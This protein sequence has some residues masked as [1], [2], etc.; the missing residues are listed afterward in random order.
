MLCIIFL[1][2]AFPGILQVIISNGLVFCVRDWECKSPDSPYQVLE[3]AVGAVVA[4]T[5]FSLVRISSRHLV[6]VGTS[7]IRS[8][9]VGGGGGESSQ[10]RNIVRKSTRNIP[11]IGKEKSIHHH[12]GDTP[13]SL[14]LGLRL[15]GVYPSF[16]TYGVH[17]FPL[18]SQENG[19]HHSFFCS[20][21]SGSGDRPRKEGSRSGGVYSFFPC[22]KIL[23]PLLLSQIAHWHFPK[24]FSRPTR[25]GY[26]QTRFSMPNMTGRPG[27][28][29]MEMNGGSSAPY[30]AR[31]PCVP[32]FCTLFNRDG[33]RRA[34]GLPGAGGDHF[35][36]TVGT[37]VRSYSVSSFFGE[38]VVCSPDSCGFR[39]FRG[40]RDCRQSNTKLLVCSC[41]SCPR[42]SRDFRRFVK[43]DPGCKI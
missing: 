12:R 6:A 1:H 2:K 43:G 35:H 27:H 34:F 5:R 19:I 39:H 37:F 24:N 17:P 29:T 42:R 14:L 11:E 13:F 25:V 4:L 16:R 21:T 33:N 9:G 36:C 23:S 20:V 15:Y 3:T 8:S 7:L 30:L 38:P 31:T 26:F 32:L 40:F 28:R 41:L 10:K 18:F 22:W